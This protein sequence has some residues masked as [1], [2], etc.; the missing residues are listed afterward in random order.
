MATTPLSD[1]KEEPTMS[2]TVTALQLQILLWQK[3]LV[4]RAQK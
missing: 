4:R 3:E 1:R 2:P